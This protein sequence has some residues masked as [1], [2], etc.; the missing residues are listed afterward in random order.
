MPDIKEIEVGCGRVMGHGESCDGARYVDDETKE[1]KAHL[2]D[3]CMERMTRYI[4]QVNLTTAVN[5]IR[6]DKRLWKRS[7]NRRVLL[8]QRALNALCA[9]IEEEA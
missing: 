3:A 7:G 5:V 1:E 8:V 2:C 9:F 4:F 6:A